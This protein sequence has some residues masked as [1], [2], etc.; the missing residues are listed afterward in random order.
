MSRE[1]ARH[2]KQRKIV[3][4]PEKLEELNEIAKKHNLDA[5]IE[6]VRLEL[7]ERCVRE[8]ITPVEA[9]DDNAYG[10]MLTVTQTYIANFGMKP[11]NLV[12]EIEDM[13]GLLRDVQAE[14]L[15]EEA[16]KH[17][18]INELLEHGAHWS[19][20]DAPSNVGAFVYPDW[21]DTKGFIRKR[22]IR[23]LQ[24]ANNT[25]N[26]RRGVQRKPRKHKKR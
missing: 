25:W 7:A 15:S 5:Q 17:N 26:S 21:I 8:G 13:I 18:M 23:A 3:V 20:E 10:F 6:Q 19:D 2:Y 16:Q 12:E 11:L 1:R 24:N 4:T 14:A 9:T 22:R